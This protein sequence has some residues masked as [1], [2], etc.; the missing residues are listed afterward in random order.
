MHDCPFNGVIFA[1]IDLQGVV[2]IGDGLLL[3][4]LIVITWQMVVRNS[5][6]LLRETP[7]E[8]MLM[9]V[10]DPQRFLKTD[11]GILQI[12]LAI[13]SREIGVGHPQVMLCISPAIGV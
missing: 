1:R 12:L 9:T 6:L 3:V 2:K 7:L 5:E 8:R 4:D 13:F 11:D 10:A